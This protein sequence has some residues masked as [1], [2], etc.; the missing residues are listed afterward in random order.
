M[1]EINRLKEAIDKA[2]V[3]GVVSHVNPDGDNLG[4]LT[5]L[6]ESLRLYGKDVK[7][8]F[9]DRMPYNLEFLHGIDQLT[10]NLD[11]EFEK[12]K[13]KFHYAFENTTYEFF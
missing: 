8:I 10:D 6:S 3:V 7:S 12:L 4:S 2:K 1:H 9:V 13:Y 11:I 5:A